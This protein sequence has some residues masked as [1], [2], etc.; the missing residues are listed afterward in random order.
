MLGCSRPLESRP[1]PAVL[2]TRFPTAHR[3]GA[4]PVP[5]PN[6]EVKP[7]FGDGTAGFPGGRVAR[8]WDLFGGAGPEGPAPLAFQGAGS[9][10]GA[11]AASASRTRLHA[12]W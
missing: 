7:C 5:I 11:A 12:S 2:T 6:T 9:A 3:A 1:G 4:T 8:R 10:A